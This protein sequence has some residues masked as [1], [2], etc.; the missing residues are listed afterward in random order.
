[1]SG[2]GAA[3]WESLKMTNI[4]SLKFVRLYMANLGTV[5]NATVPPGAIQVRARL[6]KFSGDDP[7]DG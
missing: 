3:G 1:M 7:N 5:V 6:G 4:N 2:N